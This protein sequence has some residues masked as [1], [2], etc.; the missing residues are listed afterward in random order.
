VKLS[1]VFLAGV[2]GLVVLSGLFVDHIPPHAMTV[3]RMQLLKRR[4]LQYAQSHDRLPA[5]LT[6]LPPMEGYDDRIQDGWQRDIAFEVSGDVIAFR[7]LG[8]DG[9]LGGSGDDADIVRSV[10]S[11]DAQGR[12]SEEFVAWAEN[13][14]AA[15]TR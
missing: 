7:S 1:A 12:W 9:V 5:S 15:G 6:A 14:A 13:T 3:T 11:H 2:V 8:R 10:P 4:V